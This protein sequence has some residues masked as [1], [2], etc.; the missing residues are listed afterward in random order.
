MGFHYAMHNIDS[1]DSTQ[2]VGKKIK[3]Y[4][5]GNLVKSTADSCSIA[6]N[7]TA[8]IY[9]GAEDSNSGS[10]R[11]FNGLVDDTRIYNYALTPTQIKTIMNSGTVSFQ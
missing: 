5:N 10:Q 1:V 6:V 2:T 11:N 4:F 3:I 9:I 8:D 7:T